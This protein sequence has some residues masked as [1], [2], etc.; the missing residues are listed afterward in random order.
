MYPLRVSNRQ[1]IYCGTRDVCGGLV[2]TSSATYG[3]GV[4][5]CGVKELV[6][7]ELSGT[8]TRKWRRW[9]EKLRK[10]KLSVVLLCEDTCQG[11][12]PRHGL[13]DLIDSFNVL[14]CRSKEN[15]ERAMLRT[16]ATSS[17]EEACRKFPHK[18]VLKVNCTEP[19]CCTV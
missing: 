6:S 18:R 12:C 3:A 16:E 13:V 7:G 2:R 10:W 17:V 11:C 5:W 19:R 4:W 15:T 1:Y 14:E 9:F 8:A